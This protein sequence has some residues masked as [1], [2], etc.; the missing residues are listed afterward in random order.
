MHTSHGVMVLTTPLREEVKTPRQGCHLSP[1]SV[2][3]EGSTVNRSSRQIFLAQAHVHGTKK[4]PDNHRFWLTRKVFV[5]QASRSFAE[6]L[7]GAAELRILVA[8]LHTTEECQI[9]PATLIPID[10]IQVWSAI[11][12]RQ[13]EPDRCCATTPGILRVTDTAKKKS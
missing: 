5:A 9:H 1:S 3:F 2:S 12:P 8:K 7:V 13:H 11:G 6:K 10:L 4:S